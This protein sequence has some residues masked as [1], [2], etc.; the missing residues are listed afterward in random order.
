MSNFMKSEL[1]PEFLSIHSLNPFID[2]NSSSRSQMFYSHI[3]QSLVIEASTE[4]RVSTGME[5]ELG[6]YTF[7]VQM[8]EDGVVLAVI[9][10]YSQTMGAN[11]IAFNPETIIIY[12]NEQRQIGM[13]SIPYFHKTHPYFGFKYDV[14]I[15]PDSIAINSFIPKGTIFADSPSKTENGGYKYGIELNI[16][17]MSHP[18]GAEDGIL[19]SREILPK[20]K[21][22]VFE[23]RI[24]EFGS[25]HFPLNLYGTKDKY[26]PFP[27]IGESIRRDGILMAIRGYDDDIV[28]VT[29]SSMD[30][31]EVDYVFDR[32]TYVR[33]EGGKVVDIIMTHDRNKQSKVPEEMMEHVMKYSTSL[34]QF[35]TRILELEKKIKEQRR[36]KFGSSNVTFTPPLH[37]LLVEA[38]AMLKHPPTSKDKSG[39]LTRVYKEEPIDDYRVEF[40]VEYDITP[41]IG[42]KM[43]GSYGDKGVICKIVDP[44]QMPVDADGNRADVVMDAG[45]TINRMNAGRPYEQYFGSAARDVSKLIRDTLNV[46]SYDRLTARDKVLE[47][48][49]TNPDAIQQAHRTALDLYEITSPVQYKTYSAFDWNNVVEHV[50]DIVE[51]GIRLYVPIGNEPEVVDMV[52]AVEK[53]FKLCYGPVTFFNEQGRKITTKYP[54]RIGPYY[55]M[56]LEKIGDDWSSVSY[57]KL[58]HFGILT[59]MTKFEKYSLPH[60]NS[61][62]RTMGETESRLYSSYCGIECVAEMMDRNNN[63]STHREMVRNILEAEYPSNIDSTVDR[64]KIPFGNAKPLQL[65]KHIGFC[66]GWKFSYKNDNYNFNEVAYENNTS[67]SST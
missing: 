63:P 13:V 27:D 5:R 50:Q 39:K 16:A 31:T 56:V 3:C 19:I 67:K 49:K 14:K 10:R 42:F 26:K 46:S 59:P 4:K 2:T 1:R 33:G 38:R 60:R 53:R 41:G 47:I 48:S 6:K 36:I 18:A 29:M 9:P 12:E 52:Q 22:K 57:S 66:Y 7:S 58:H 15:P 55:M 34:E 35:Y 30:L 64:T 20:L 32:S 43:T 28:P 65:V 17:F 23:T 21:F 54:V 45:S 25:K 24:V 11:N 62:I 8:P 37:R 40:V 51:D 44:E 61:P